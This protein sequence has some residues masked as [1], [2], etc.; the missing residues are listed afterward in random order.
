[1]RK[2]N[3]KNRFVRI[4]KEN[5]KELNFINNEV[6]GLGLI[7]LSLNRFKWKEIFPWNLIITLSAFEVN[8]SYL[9][10]KEEI[11]DILLYRSELESKFN[12]E[13][14]PNVLFVASVFTDSECD[15]N[16]R[17]NNADSVDLIL[18][19][20]I[21]NKNHKFEFNYRMDHDINWERVEDVIDL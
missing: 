7:N 14:K 11:N 18:K 20:I 17:V 13:E 9:P 2:L 8:E 3:R 10:E 16:W 21:K 15:F 6:E 1:M 5:L 19:E 12:Q 4:K